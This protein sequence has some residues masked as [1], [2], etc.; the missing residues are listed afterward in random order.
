MKSALAVRVGKLIQGRRFRVRFAEDDVQKMK[1][2]AISLPFLV[3]D[4]ANSVKK[5]QNLL[6]AI[7]TGAMDSRRELYTTAKMRYTP[8]QARIWMTANTASL[9]NETISGRMLIIDAAPRTEAEPYR[10]EHYLEWSDSLRNDIWTELIGRLAAAMYELKCADECG[11][12]DLHVDH[13]MSSFFVLGRALARQG[14]Y[15]GKFLEAMKRMTTR[16]QGASAEGNDIVDLVKMLPTSC[17]GVMRPAKEWSRL[18]TNMVPERNR[19]LTAKVSRVGWV[20][21]QFT[22]EYHTL[23]RE[24]GMKCDYDAHSKTNLY[25]FSKLEGREGKEI[26][27]DVL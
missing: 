10:S 26:G 21:W 19:E 15:E 6:K 12:G 14:G 11:Q 23:T 27:V 2:L 25:S 9:T 22:S 20:S 1:D 24:C 16:Q 7:G 4:E 3:L 8:Y 17:A 13:R 18:L 5:L